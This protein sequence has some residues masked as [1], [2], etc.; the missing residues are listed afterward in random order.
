MA[1]LHPSPPPLPLP[2][3]AL[4]DLYPEA[5]R[6]TIHLTLNGKVRTMD[7]A[8]SEQL[9]KCLLRIQLNASDKKQR[10]KK[11]KQTESVAPSL[12]VEL[13]SNTVPVDSE[14][15][16]SEAWK[17]NCVLR[18]GT[19]E[20]Q[21]RLNTP[22]VLSLSLPKYTLQDC[23]IVPQVLLSRCERHSCHWGWYR[24]EDGGF[25]EETLSLALSHGTAGL[26]GQLTSTFKLIKVSDGFT[27]SPH[28]GDVGHKLLVLCQPLEP[29]SKQHSINQFVVTP[30]EVQL[31]PK[32]EG[33]VDRF[34]WTRQL[35]DT[36]HLRVV[37][38]NVRSDSL[39]LLICINRAFCSY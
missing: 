25:S 15:C 31:F 37:S 34:M 39:G 2:H 35:T 10:C 38:Y 11:N 28:A 18:V 12:T 33:Q 20:F 9:K 24:I 16:N 36:N 6:L 5:D 14:I 23:P 21:V 4:V 27:Y 32:L 8:G 7:R 22:R 13:L 26:S 19:D 3:L 29:T 1:A 30:N 17:D